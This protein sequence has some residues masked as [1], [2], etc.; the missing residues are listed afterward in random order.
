MFSLDINTIGYVSSLECEYL[1]IAFDLLIKLD[2]VGP[3]TKQLNH[4]VKKK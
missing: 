1:K 2:R 3:S 4:F